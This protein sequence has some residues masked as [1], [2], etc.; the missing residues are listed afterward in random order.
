MYIYT[1][2]KRQAINSTSHAASS[3]ARYSVVSS[4]LPGVI[5]KKKISL[6]FL[7]F[8]EEITVGHGVVNQLNHCWNPFLEVSAYS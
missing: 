7:S 1:K 8:I 3:L 2:R 5:K 4:S 6:L